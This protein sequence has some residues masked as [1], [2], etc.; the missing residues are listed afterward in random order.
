MGLG[1]GVCVWTGPGVNVKIGDVGR[2]MFEIWCV[3]AGPTLWTWCG[4][5]V[6]DLWAEEDVELRCVEVELDDEEA[7]ACC[8]SGICEKG[9]QRRYMRLQENVMK[10][11]ER[12]RKWMHAGG[13]WPPFPAAAGQAPDE[14]C[15]E[16]GDDLRDS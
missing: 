16:K 11:E 2:G 3:A 1:T 4:I 10:N 15:R 8:R 12:N 14:G 9:S 13:L 7:T 6:E 5:T